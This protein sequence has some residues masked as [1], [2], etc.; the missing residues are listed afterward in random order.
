MGGFVVGAAC[1]GAP[2]NEWELGGLARCKRVL[3]RVAPS[4]LEALTLFVQHSGGQG[5]PARKPGPP[6]PLPSPSGLPVQGPKVLG[7]APYLAFFFFQ[8]D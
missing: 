5:P 1:E 4:L 7:D 8:S 3:G 2:N 6:S